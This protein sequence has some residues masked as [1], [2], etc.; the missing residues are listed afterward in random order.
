[1]VVKIWKVTG[2]TNVKRDGYQSI[3]NT[4]LIILEDGPLLKVVN[5]LTGETIIDSQQEEMEKV[6]DVR[7]VSEL[8]GLL[9]EYRNE[10]IQGLS[11]YDLTGTSRWNQTFDVKSSSGLEAVPSPLTDNAGNLYY[12]IG[13]TTAETKWENWRDTLVERKKERR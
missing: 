3:P 5:G 2:L 12:G 10:K 4:P 7:F 13:K 9:I 11:Y 6:K 8:E 1:M